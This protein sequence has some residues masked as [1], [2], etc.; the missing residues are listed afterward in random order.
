M[1]QVECAYNYVVHS[2]IGKSPF[3]LVYTYVPKHVVDLVRLPKAPGVSVAAENMAQNIIYM[4][5]IV[6]AKLEAIGKKNKVAAS[7]RKRIK[8]FK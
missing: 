3:S 2:A 8:V 5:E 4:K 6:K 1:S 7:K